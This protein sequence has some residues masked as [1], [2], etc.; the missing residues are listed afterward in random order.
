[1]EN[2]IYNN[3]SDY[4]IGLA[5]YS[6]EGVMNYPVKDMEST[7][8]VKLKGEEILSLLTVLEARE[9][10]DKCYYTRDEDKITIVVNLAALERIN[11]ER[12]AERLEKEDTKA[13]REDK[14]NRF[15]LKRLK[16]ENLSDWEFVTTLYRIS[17]KIIERL[18]NIYESVD[19]CENAGKGEEGLIEDLKKFDNLGAWFVRYI[20]GAKEVELKN[21]NRKGII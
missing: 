3:I 20:E 16:D 21:R 8:K 10:I 12:A 9:E 15:L 17:P 1:M 2:R 6:K 7:F 13:E 5:S 11:R 4:M 14:H 19:S 18:I